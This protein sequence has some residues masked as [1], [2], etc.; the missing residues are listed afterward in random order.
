M[1]DPTPTVIMTAGGHSEYRSHP[2]I[3]PDPW[4]CMWQ[5][6]EDGAWETDCNECFQF[7]EGGP[8]DNRWEY[9]P[10]CGNRIKESP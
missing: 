4:F 8:H 1:N 7:N 2:E 9:C 6:D 10:Y 5:Q 3:N